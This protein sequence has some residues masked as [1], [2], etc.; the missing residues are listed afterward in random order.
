MSLGFVTQVA[1]ASSCVWEPGSIDARP[2]DEVEG[3]RF[4]RGPHGV[5][6]RT[7][8]DTRRVRSFQVE[9]KWNAKDG[10]VFMLPSIGC[11]C[12]QR[13]CTCTLGLECVRIGQLSL[14]FSGPQNFRGTSEA[15]FA[16]QL[17]QT[18]RI[19]GV[20]QTCRV[21]C[22]LWSSAREGSNPSYLARAVELATHPSDTNLRTVEG[23][24][25]AGATAWDES[26]VSA[27]L[28]RVPSRRRVAL[29]G[30]LS[31]PTG[32][33]LHMVYASP[34]FFPSDLLLL[35]SAFDN[36]PPGGSILSILGDV[37]LQSSKQIRQVCVSSDEDAALRPVLPAANV[38]PF[39][40]TLNCA[41]L[42]MAV[43]A[44][45]HQAQASV[46]HVNVLAVTPGDAG[47]T[48]SDA[49]ALDALVDKVAK[50]AG[51]DEATCAQAKEL[52]GRCGGLE[53]RATTVRDGASELLSHTAVTVRADTRLAVRLRF[54]GEEG[55]LAA[56]IITHT[57][58][59]CV[60]TATVRVAL[61]NYASML[62]KRSGVSQ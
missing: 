46:D 61:Y 49:D 57:A 30:Q 53:S 20:V 45:R 19:R 6:V 4:V 60:A 39:R 15:A 35:K 56:G 17:R 36:A 62:C 44:W 48:S 38:Y 50:G 3:T 13:A 54:C 25:I 9:A 37:L 12:G 16:E 26:L 33:A 29:W 42:A 27:T 41:I 28:H 51:A 43:A 10:F 14:A 8:A 40:R 52:T 21:C 5:D 32:T 24:A 23:L 2:D 7:L 1:H 47:D 11:W 22:D 59:T 34:F 31:V 18:E 58:G 55:V